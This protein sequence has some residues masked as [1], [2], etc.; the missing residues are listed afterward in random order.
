MMQGRHL[1]RPRAAVLA[2]L[3]LLWCCVYTPARAAYDHELEMTV[4]HTQVLSFNRVA[5][6]AIGDGSLV[7][8]RVV[9]NTRQVLLLA[10]AA[11]VTD[12]RV[13]HGNNELSSYQVRVVQRPLSTVAEQVATRLDR[14]EG[15][16]VRIQGQQVLVEGRT[17][18][19]TDSARVAAV[20]T[21]FPEAV[22][23]VEPAKFTLQGMIRLDVKVLE[24][25]R[26]ALTQVGV[27]W[28]DA[29][30]GLT[31]GTIRN[32]HTNPH[33]N[34]TLN[35][36]PSQLGQT[37]SAFNS[38][39]SAS[40]A[41]IAS[42][43]GSV[44]NLLVQNGLAR[45]LAEPKLS[46]KSGGEAQFVVGGE[47]PIPVTNVDGAISVSF[48]E[49][50]VI[51]KMSPVSDPDGYISTKV[52]VEVS[53]VDPSI[54]VLGIPGFATRK[55]RTEMNVHDGETMVLAGL[56]SSE[57]SKDIEKVPGVGNL[58]I[59][60]ELFKSRRFRNRETELVVFVTPR[61]VGPASE[62]NKAWLDRARELTKTSSE[63]LRFHLL[64]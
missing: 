6:V 42:R 24:I 55:T 11:G 43:F 28:D 32:F 54:S 12:M 63:N 3:L 62:E 13:W 20:L 2:T 56:I 7:E 37:A 18:N 35:P 39:G 52:D 19:E 57:R 1:V 41:G 27:N 60:G 48:K 22:N 59:I 10:R 17:L 25:N 38:G 21:S 44:I 36:V 50:G 16:S 45:L 61:L 33:F 26:S 4:G 53:T 51:L 49:F 40:Y 47:V 30:E 64:D 58:P 31:F 9:D 23:A 15:V 5:R 46:C 29:I 8:V 34:P 14:V